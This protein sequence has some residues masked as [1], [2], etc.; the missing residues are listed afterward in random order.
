MRVGY[1][2]SKLAG[3]W[4]WV[5]VSEQAVQN[6]LRGAVDVGC[7]RGRAHAARALSP[8]FLAADLQ[9]QLAQWLC[10]PQLWCGELIY[11]K[12]LPVREIN[13]VDGQLVA[14]ANSARDGTTA[15]AATTKA[16]S[17]FR[18][19]CKGSPITPSICDPDGR[20]RTG[21][22]ARGGS[23]V[24]RRRNCRAAFSTFYSEEDRSVTF[25]RWHFEPRKRRADTTLRAGGCARTALAFGPAL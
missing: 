16:N 11:A 8:I 25:R 2:R 21:M 24:Y 6:S 1:A 20:L 10:R 13:D 17:S 22:P 5:S 19:S 15:C 7:A 18:C 14:A 4:I 3:W 12:G 23:K 9:A